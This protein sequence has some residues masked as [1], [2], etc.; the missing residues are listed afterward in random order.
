MVVDAA[1]SGVSYGAAATLP[2]ERALGTAMVYAY[3]DVKNLVSRIEMVGGGTPP[4]QE[5]PPN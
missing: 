5:P 2:F 1:V 3:L 4:P